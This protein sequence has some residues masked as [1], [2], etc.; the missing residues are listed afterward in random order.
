MRNAAAAAG[1]GS[2]SNNS[3]QG[4]FLIDKIRVL[5]FPVKSEKAFLR[6]IPFRIWLE[7]SLEKT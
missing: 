1:R 3:L 4:S 6:E 2:S 7:N 5:F